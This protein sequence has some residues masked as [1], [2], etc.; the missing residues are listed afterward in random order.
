MLLKLLRNI[1]NFTFHKYFVLIVLFYLLFIRYLF[2]NIYFQ[3]QKHFSRNTRVLFFY[4]HILK[5]FVMH[6]YVFLAP[7]NSVHYS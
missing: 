3:F 5:L 6:V 4:V 1:C 2:F 7:Y